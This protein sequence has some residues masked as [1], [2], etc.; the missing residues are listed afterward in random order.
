MASRHRFQ[1]AGETH[2]VTLEE[3][4]DGRARVRVGEG[5]AKDL[6]V[7]TAGVPGLFSIVHNGVPTQA[8]VARDGHGFRVTVD[9]RT[10]HLAP[11]SG[12]GRQRG[13]AGGMVDPPGT[14]TAPLAGV[15]VELRVAVGDTIQPRQTVAVV[16]AMKMQNEVQAPMAGTVT[17]IQAVAGARIEKGALVLAYEPAEAPE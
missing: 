14:I 11:A 4:A 6:D 2:T 7:T 13:A 12:A 3:L 5:D 10:F 16:E 1:V 8:Y 15:V 9:G 17:R